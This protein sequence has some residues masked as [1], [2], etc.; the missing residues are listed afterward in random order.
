MADIEWDSIAEDEFMCSPDGPVMRQL[1]PQLGAELV[2]RAYVLC[3]K[4]S[5]DTAK[6][7]RISE[8]SADTRGPFVRVGAD[9]VGLFLEHPAKQ[10]HRRYPFL[11]DAARS[12]V[13]GS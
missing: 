8:L 4:R 12:M 3:P 1:L 5:G 2:R 10:M 13:A 6:T 11:S 9:Y 7:I